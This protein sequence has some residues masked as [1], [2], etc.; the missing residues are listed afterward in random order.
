VTVAIQLDLYPQ[1]I[2]WRIDRIGSTVDE[3]TRVPAGIYKT[4]GALEVKTVWVERGGLY[5]FTIFDVVGDGMCCVSGEGAYQVSL[6]TTDVSDE[7]SIIIASTGD[8]QYG[9][10]HT[11]LASLDDGQPENSEDS[12]SGGGPFLTLQ[13]QFDEYPNET[14]WIL[15]SDYG[16]S[17]EARM[18]GKQAITTSTIAFRPPL[19]Y[20][21]SLANQLVTETIPVPAVNA[22]YTFIFTDSYGDG[23]CCES[24]NGSYSIWKGPLEN[25][26]LL[27]SGDSRGSSHEV[28]EF[29]LSFDSSTSSG[30]SNHS[31]SSASSIF[32]LKSTY[33]YIGAFSSVLLATLGCWLINF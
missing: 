10:E 31:T 20:D 6:G 19:H 7:S 4:P 3:V 28:K 26:E 13:I 24:G 32:S 18:E 22:A 15:R 1:E 21:A 23:L 12:S 17:S 11:F 2:G 16:V 14:G 33:P 30:S 29:M 8:F 5:S 25:N 9:M 27:A